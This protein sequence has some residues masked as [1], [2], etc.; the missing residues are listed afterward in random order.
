MS[1]PSS[2][3]TTSVPLTAAS[4]ASDNEQPSSIA[5]DDTMASELSLD[6]PVRGVVSGR[7]ST[8]GRGRGGRRGT[9]SNRPPEHY[10][11]REA[12]IDVSSL[13]YV[14]KDGKIMPCKLCMY[15]G[16]KLVDHYVTK[17]PDIEVLISR[18]DQKEALHA[19]LQSKKADTQILQCR[20]CHGNFSHAAEFLDHVAEHTGEYRYSCTLCD[21]KKPRNSTV[22][23]HLKS[24]HSNNQPPAFIG[25]SIDLDSHYL[26]GFLCGF[27]NFVQ[28]DKETVL[29]HVDKRH[30]HEAG[31]VCTPGLEEVN[32][33]NLVKMVEAEEEVDRPL[34]VTLSSIK[35]ETANLVWNFPLFNFI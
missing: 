18:L 35:V 25:K 23:Q 16:K 9:R 11:E 12:V 19:I 14:W 17:H 1:R 3:N 21:Y 34:P 13:A 30:R 29:K 8:R 28:M 4:E 31:A 22:V 20:F 15:E 32:E 26:P 7:G 24:A 10:P 27:C 6:V 5:S 33:I 2:V